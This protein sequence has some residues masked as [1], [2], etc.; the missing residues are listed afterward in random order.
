MD[1][2]VIFLLVFIVYTVLLVVSL[3]RVSQVSKELSKLSNEVD[4]LGRSLRDYMISHGAGS[5]VDV[6][7]AVDADALAAANKI[8][9]SASDSDL[10]AATDLLSQ[11]GVK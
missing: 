1:V 7:N 10:K 3:M 8:L 2:A 9:E 5:T 4:A 6:A 11:L